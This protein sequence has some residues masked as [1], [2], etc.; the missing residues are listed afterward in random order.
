MRRLFLLLRHDIFEGVLCKWKF[1]L[2]A[3][4][5]FSFADF[6]FLN[7]VNSA[8]AASGNNIRCS[9]A[10]FMLN[11]FAGN[12][13]FDPQT[14]MRVNLSVIWFLFHA[15]LFSIIGFYISDDLKKS[16]SSFIL[17]V[18]SKK[19]W[20]TSKALWCIVTVVL[21]YCLFFAVSLIFSAFFGNVS[22]SPNNMI[23]VEM[24]NISVSKVTLFKMV[25]VSFLLPMMISVS[26]AVFEA[27]LCLLVKPIFSFISIICYLAVS[28]FYCKAYLLFNFSMIVRNNFESVNFVSNVCG[29]LIALGLTVVCYLIGLLIIKKKDII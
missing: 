1:F 8:F 20:W 13:P 5:F 14:K 26:F 11:M 15:F 18:Q 9:T 3:A 28:A 17:R 19:Q 29:L 16:A 23:A 6:M 4:L 7:N 22:L 12:E 24:L 21:Y 25:F 10:D 27:M 2:I